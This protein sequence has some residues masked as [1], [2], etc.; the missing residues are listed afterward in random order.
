MAEIWLQPLSRTQPQAWQAKYP[1]QRNPEP[2]RNAWTGDRGCLLEVVAPVRSVRVP[3]SVAPSNDQQWCAQMSRW[4]HRAVRAQTSTGCHKSSSQKLTGGRNGKVW[5]ASS[6]PPWTGAERIQ[7]M[8]PPPSVPIPHC[9]PWLPLRSMGAP[10]GW[11]RTGPTP[12]PPA[13]PGRRC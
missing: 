6:V 11:Q 7:A 8:S 2:W 9:R 1:M 4:A 10:K 3:G 12:R 5:S 13:E